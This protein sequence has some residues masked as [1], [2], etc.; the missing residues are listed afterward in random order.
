MES[1][2]LGFLLT[3]QLRRGMRSLQEYSI[4]LWRYG[5]TTRIRTWP[6]LNSLIFPIWT[7]ECDRYSI[8]GIS[9]QKSTGNLEYIGREILVT[10]GVA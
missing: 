4:S 6:A 8:L 9:E 7:S 2:F 5:R 10:S 3:L 1:L